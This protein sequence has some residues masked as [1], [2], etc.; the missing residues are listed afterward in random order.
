MGWPAPLP[1]QMRKGKKG[2]WKSVKLINIINVINFNNV[3]PNT[4]FFIILE[5]LCQIL[6]RGREHQRKNPDRRWMAFLRFQ[7]SALYYE[8]RG[9]FIRC[10]SDDTKRS[11]CLICRVVSSV[12]FV[13]ETV[14]CRFYRFFSQAIPPENISYSRRHQWWGR[15]AVQERFVA[16]LPYKIRSA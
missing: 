9:M 14:T 16:K 4:P 8:P 2:T 7:M 15:A 1:E 10:I 13:I 5:S 6:P 12:C 11:S 3:N